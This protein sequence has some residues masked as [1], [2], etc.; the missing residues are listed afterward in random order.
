ML[1]RLA[2]VL[3]CLSM[4]TDL[5]DGFRLEK[6]MRTA[7]LARSLARAVGAAPETQVAAYYAAVVRFVGCTA[8]AVEEATL[9]AAGDDIG[10]R[11]ILA[12]AD[13]GSKVDVVRRVVP[14]LARGAPLRRRA[15]AVARFLG[16][17][18]APRTHAQAEC[19]VGTRL[20]RQ[21]DLGDTVV[22]A[23][24][25]RS[26]RF[27]GRGARRKGAGTA[28]PLVARVVEVADMADLFFEEGDT[29]ASVAAV[30]ARRGGQLDPQIA[31]AFTDAP[32]VHLEPLRAPSI[33]DAY[34]DAE[35]DAPREVDGAGLERVARAFSRVVDLKSRFTLGHSA[36]V[37]ALVGAACDA[38]GVG[39]EQRAAAMVAG[40]LHDLGNLA[41]PTGLLDK[42]GPLTS[43][44]RE[45]VRT[46]AH[47]TAFVL[48]A[49]GSLAPIADLAGASH[50]YAGGAGYPRGGGWD[51]LLPGARLLMAADVACALGEPRAYRRA[52]DTTSTA[53]TLRAMARDGQLC[54][55]A[56]EAVL[57]ASGHAAPRLS[58][59][60]GRWPR[61]LTDREVE[62]LR[63]V[64]VGRTNREIGEM[65]SISARTA[66]KHVMN[67]YDKIG[68]SSRAAAALFA[69]ESGIL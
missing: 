16:S 59:S 46:H 55:R 47:H 57:E 2:E 43:W 64:A 54:P 15:A 28:V 29:G 1:A 11:S 31:D 8:F 23:L 61:S 6:A 26:E 53:R 38:A 5:T 17:P 51:A 56:T 49:S 65:L 63:L 41:V 10:L 9:Y 40:L 66:Q 25:F 36:A 60:S 4:G 68:V 21:L 58:P 39:G 24:D 20:A 50:E 19:E 67:V 34:L 14:H 7:V 27:D 52:H 22:Q 12:R 30:R 42:P 13:F 48:R 44:E 45:R 69:M 62:V 33:W 3:G 35:G 32:E 18:A 37:A